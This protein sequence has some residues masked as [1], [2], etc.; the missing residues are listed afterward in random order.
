VYIRAGLYQMPRHEG[1]SEGGADTQ[2]ASP[3][4]VQGVNIGPQGNEEGPQ[5]GVLPFRRYMQ[6]RSASGIGGMD[7]YLPQ[8]EGPGLFTFTLFQNCPDIIIRL[9]RAAGTG[10][11]YQGGD[12]TE[13]KNK[14]SQWIYTLHIPFIGGRGRELEL[15]PQPGYFLKKV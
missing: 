4:V 15:S 12:K 11:Q 1:V 7:I 13:D 14:L 10:Q 8:K 9:R 3:F 6:G 5:L 2:G